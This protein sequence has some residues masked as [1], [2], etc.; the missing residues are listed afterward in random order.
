ME[1]FLLRRCCVQDSF[2]LYSPV[3]FRNDKKRSSVSHRC[4]RRNNCIV[5]LAGK[6]SNLK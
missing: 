4:K 6:K 1:N 3:I 2:L 5:L